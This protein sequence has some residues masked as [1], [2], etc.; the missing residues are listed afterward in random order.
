MLR[1]YYMCAVEHDR[2]I[3]LFGSRVAIV[4]EKAA[5]CRRKNLGQHPQML[6]FQYAELEA[7]LALYE[8]VRS[9]NMFCT[10]CVAWVCLYIAGTL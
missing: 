4:L 2:C 5:R 6:R 1:M 3:E 9:A 7:G 10:V 8:M